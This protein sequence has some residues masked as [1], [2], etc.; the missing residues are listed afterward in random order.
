ML[1]ILCLF[2]TASLAALCAPYGI[3]LPPD[4]A[5]LPEGVPSA[6][7]FPTWETLQP[8]QDEWDFTAAETLVAAAEKQDIR[9]IGKLH[10]LAPWTTD[11]AEPDDFPLENKDAWRNFTANL[12]TRYGEKVSHWDVLDSFNLLP[13]QAASPYHYVELLTIARENARKIYPEIRI[14]F[15]LGNYDLEFLDSAIRDGAAGNFDYISL[16]PFPCHQENA[17]VFQTVLPTLRE[18][19]ESHGID[20]LPVHITLTGS[21]EDIAAIAPLAIAAGFDEVFLKCEPTL[22]KD[23]PAEAAE[24]PASKSYADAESV[25]ITLGKKNETDG[26]HQLIPSATAWD[27]ETGANRLRVTANPPQ[28]R[29]AFLADPTFLTPQDRTIEITVTAKRIDSED[30]RQ[31][32]AGI[33][34]AYDS[35]HGIRTVDLWWAVPGDNKWHTHTWK[36]TD[37]AFQSK[38][39]WNFRLDSSGAG[40]DV[41]IS[42]VEVKR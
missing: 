36:L 18:L 4:T 30:G 9:L 11:D 14:G 35:V 25:S 22:L 3:A 42:K 41:L 8:D 7:V 38:L 1:R 29:T 32:P 23:V 40:N 5:N 17:R 6:R 13:R 2:L 16:S 26:L 21:D 37:A 10:Q 27:E 28:V 19:L 12:F 34:L 31:N 33:N 15:V 24:L 20:P 39:G